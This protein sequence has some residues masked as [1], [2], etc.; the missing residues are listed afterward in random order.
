MLWC[1]HVQKPVF[2]VF[3]H[4]V[5]QHTCEHSQLKTA[6]CPAARGGYECLGGYSCCDQET[7]G[8]GGGC[9]TVRGRSQ[10]GNSQHPASVIAGGSW[11]WVPRALT[12]GVDMGNGGLWEYNGGC[13][14]GCEV[15]NL[16]FHTSHLKVAHV[17]W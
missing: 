5:E 13:G 12:Q 15:T 10:L 7:C 9:V 11:V 1:E 16:R 4:L 6:P 14:G 3:S 17:E 8:A 2:G